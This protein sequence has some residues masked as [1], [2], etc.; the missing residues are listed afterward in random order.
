MSEYRLILCP[1]DFSEA[2]KRAFEA[3]LD[4]AARLKAEVRVIHVYE[5]PASV[6]PEGVLEAPSD[7]EAVIEERLQK[8]LDA[9]VGD[10]AAE[11]VNVTTGV[12]E[13]VAYVEITEAAKELDA[14]MIVIGTHGRTGLAHMLLGSVAEHVIRISDVPVLTVRER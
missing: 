2:S 5:L 4:L 12:C 7:L 1:V 14:D 8:R 11:R 9:F 3:A 6:L 13:G 10:G